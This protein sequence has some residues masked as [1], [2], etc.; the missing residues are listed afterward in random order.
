MTRRTA[1]LDDLSEF[2]VDENGRLYWRGKAVIFERRVGLEGPTFWLPLR[3]PYRRS[4]L[5]SGLFSIASTFSA[6]EP[7]PRNTVPSAASRRLCI[8]AESWACP[9]MGSPTLRVAGSGRIVRSAVPTY[10][11]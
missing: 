2:E 6:S 11:D 8:W 10:S 7:A 5:P 1:T 4:S 3:P 9:E